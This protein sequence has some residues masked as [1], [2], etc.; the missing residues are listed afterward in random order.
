M[1]ERTTYEKA[2][3]QVMNLWTK[4][5]LVERF[6]FGRRLARTA[7]ELMGVRGVRL[8]HDQALYK[9]PGGG[10]TPS[11]ADQH[12]WPRPPARFCTPAVPL[13]ATPSARGPVR[14]A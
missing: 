3:L 14:S 2:F 6:V 9:E 10:F 11:H 8:Y 12:D 4:S 13:P 1:E 7:A 5:A